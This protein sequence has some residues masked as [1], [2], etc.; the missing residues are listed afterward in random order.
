MAAILGSNQSPRIVS[1]GMN[2]V[3]RTGDPAPGVPVSTAQVS[4][5]IVQAYFGMVG[6][7]LTLGQND[8]AQVT[9][10]AVGSTTP[11]TLYGGVYQ[12]V[13]FSSAQ[14]STT[15]IG[16]IVMWVN[17]TLLSGSPSNYTVT[18]D[19]TPTRANFVAGIAV[20]ATAAGNYDFV[21]IAGIATVKFPS[22]LQAATPAIGDAIFVS[23]NIQS[24]QL[25]DDREGATVSTTLLKQFIGVAIQAPVASTSKAVLLDSSR[26]V[27]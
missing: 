9:G 25:A 6:G 1:Q 16:C 27:Y 23:S 20:N 4:G 2:A 13:Q 3:G 15:S 18:A 21:Q 11:N 8:A 5:S 22:A 14:T 26:W 17:T 7:K 10:A 24:P 19:G 12:Y